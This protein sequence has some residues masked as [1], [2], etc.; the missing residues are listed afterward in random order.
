MS[1]ADRELVDLRREIIEARN[2]A[3]KTDN[4]VKNLSL[5]VKGF[6][7]RFDS[8]ERRTR[9]SGLGVH[10]IVAVTIIAAAYMVQSVRVRGLEQDHAKA[11]ADV[12]GE[13]QSVEQSAD[14]LSKR[15]AAVEQERRR[16]ERA[17]ASAAKLNEHLDN[18]REK[19]AAD[20][21]ESLDFASLTP[22]ESRLLDKRV[23][24]LRVRSGDASYR[25]ARSAQLMNRFDIAANE[26]KR[27]LTLDPK[28]ETPAARAT[29]SRACSST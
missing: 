22:L 15:L 23:A 28:D 12:R 18:R 5:D 25:A 29:I 13:K 3:I 17:A 20:L 2:Q 14:S 10:L 7:K 16:Y 21:L 27:C 6:E 26:F 24:D 9:I 19:E 1:D 8:L 11:L 4:Q